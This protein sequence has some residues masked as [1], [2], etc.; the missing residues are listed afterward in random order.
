[1]KEIFEALALRIRSPLCG[2]FLLAFVA[3]NWEPLYFL[4]WS[5]DKV[6]FR[7]EY[8]HLHTSWVTFFAVPVSF[9]IGWTLAYPWVN[10]LFIKLCTLPTVLKNK[11]QIE[12]EHLVQKRSNELEDERNKENKLRI[13]K[14]RILE[15][16]LID[17]AK[18]DQEIEG[19]SDEAIKS[20]LKKEV[21]GIRGTLNGVLPNISGNLRAS[22]DDT[23]GLKELRK[24]DNPEAVGI[25]LSEL[26]KL[27]DSDYKKL[28]I[29]QLKETEDFLNSDTGIHLRQLIEDE[30]KTSQ[31][32]N[33]DLK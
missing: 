11:M 10:L 24:F 4:F 2:Y 15:Q 31:K 26:N 8:F 18:S 23:I 22:I 27:N 32:L 30:L 7:I 20:N 9:S 33:D 19:I 25:A 14:N 13:E 29:E 3:C 6:M 28:L 16:E 5:N 12:A 21:E 17:R 1:M